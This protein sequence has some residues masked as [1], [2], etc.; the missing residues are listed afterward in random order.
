MDPRSLHI[1]NTNPMFSFSTPLISM[2]DTIGY[3]VAIIPMDIIEQLPPMPRWRT[4]GTLNG[5]PFNLAIC[6]I[7]TGERYFIVGSSL[8]KAAKVMPN[9][10]VHIAF[11]LTDPD[12]LEIPE[13]F[14]ECL[15]QD[16]VGEQ[17]WNELTIGKQRSILHYITSTSKTDTRIKRSLELLDKLKANQLYIAKRK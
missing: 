10:E 2:V 4:E 8:R 14:L 7:K 6:K 17:R 1:M 5:V 13:E 9:T 16:R 15:R 12:K 11:Q 3:V